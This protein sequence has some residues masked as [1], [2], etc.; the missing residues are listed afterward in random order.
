MYCSSNIVADDARF[1]RILRY[2]GIHRE[3]PN[4]PRHTM[5]SV[6]YLRQTSTGMFDQRSCPTGRQARAIKSIFQYSAYVS[7]P[8]DTFNYLSGNPYQSSINDYKRSWRDSVFLFLSLSL[9]RSDFLEKFQNFVIRKRLYKTPHRT[10]NVSV[11]EYKVSWLTHSCVFKS[12][13]NT[14]SQYHRA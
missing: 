4:T 2:G 1:E 7:L 11:Q 12:E 13:K 8:V 9:N 3:G 5:E 10:Q 14:Q 6:I